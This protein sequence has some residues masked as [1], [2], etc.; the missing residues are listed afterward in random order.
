MR[1]VPGTNSG[2]LSQYVDGEIPGLE[3]GTAVDLYNDAINGINVDAQTNLNL[4]L[5]EL[6]TNYQQDEDNAFP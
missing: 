6:R 3:D 5:D 4:L 2:L 1:S